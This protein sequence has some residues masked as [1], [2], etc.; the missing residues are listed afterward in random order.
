M[1]GNALLGNAY[2][3]GE[4]EVPVSL[5]ESEAK[6]NA[7]TFSSDSHGV[8]QIGRQPYRVPGASL[9]CKAPRQPQK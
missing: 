8:R 5:T 4:R 9:L 2:V 1:Y 3:N 6:R 7:E